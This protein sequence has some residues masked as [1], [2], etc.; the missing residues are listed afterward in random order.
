MVKVKN[1]QWFVPVTP[2]GT[3]LDWLEAPTEEEAWGNLMEDAAH[4]PYPD[5]AAFIK[6]GYT[7]E[8]KGE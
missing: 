3:R 5:R 6:R 2:A 8:E 4:M 7:V 1:E